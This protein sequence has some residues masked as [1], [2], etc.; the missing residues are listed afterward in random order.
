MALETLKGVEEIGGYK[1]LQ[2]RPM[3][4]PGHPAPPSEVVVDWRKFDE[5]RKTM[6]IYVDHEVNMISFR[7]QDGPIKENGVNG[8]QVDT[9]IHAAERILTEFDKKINCV[10]N[11]MA[12]Q[13]LRSAI[14]ELNLRTEDREK[15]GVEGTSKA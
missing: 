6:P 8:C 2:E 5:M 13:G 11:Q 15:R 12:L 3:R 4:R 9:L 10:H 1:V 7:I 14:H